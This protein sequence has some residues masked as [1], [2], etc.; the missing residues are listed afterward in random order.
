[1]VGKVIP[2]PSV[3]AEKTYKQLLNCTLIGALKNQENFFGCQQECHQ[4][5]AASDSLHADGLDFEATWTKAGV[6][7]L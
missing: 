6:A 1:M 4:T 3:Q 7:Q 5:S 2:Y